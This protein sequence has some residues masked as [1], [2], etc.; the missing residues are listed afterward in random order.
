MSSSRNVVKLQR[1]L[2]RLERYSRHGCWTWRYWNKHR[3]RWSSGS[4]GQRSVVD[5][6]RW[7]IQQ[8]AKR[9]VSAGQSPITPILFSTV[10]L[11][12]VETRRQGLRC[13]RLRA[14]SLRKI[15]TTLS[16]FERFLG[17]DYSTLIIAGVDAGCLDRFL[18]AQASRVSTSV[19]NSYLEVISQI[20]G[21]AVKKRIP[22]D[23][24]RQEGRT[25]LRQS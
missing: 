13:R 15:D 20:L 18:L 11:E 23:Q 19:A 3:N 17:R 24:P 22:S 12:Y 4:T 10:A 2:G 1:G 7:V 14:S 8:A 16:V 5:A 21:F 6:R 25:A 9:Q